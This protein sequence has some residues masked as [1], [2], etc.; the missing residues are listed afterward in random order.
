MGS[1]EPSSMVIAHILEIN[2]LYNVATAIK[3]AATTCSSHT[4]ISLQHMHKCMG[5]MSFSSTRIMVSNGMVEGIEI[6]SQPDNNFCNMCVKA[7]ITHVPSPA[8]SNTHATK[9]GEWIH[10]DVW[11]S[12]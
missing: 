12:A 4:H 8:E 1:P 5:H 10:T 3:V 7:K 11:G 2:G 6:A 9:Y